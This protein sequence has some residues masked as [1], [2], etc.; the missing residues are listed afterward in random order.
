MPEN[1]TPTAPTPEVCH[2]INRSIRFGRPGQ[3]MA[4]YRY[5]DIEKPCFDPLRTP[6][7][8]NI[9]LFQPVD[10]IWHRGLW[11]ALKYVN[12]ENFWEEYVP[13]DTSGTKYGRHFYTAP[14]TIDADADGRVCARGEVAWVSRVS[15]EQLIT[16]TR[17]IGYADHGSWLTLDCS[18][19]LLAHQD[20]HL[21][22]HP[23]KG[24]GGYSGLILRAT[25]DWVET[26]ITLADGTE[27]PR[28]TGQQAPWAALTGLFDGAF[29]GEPG[30]LA[31]LDHP[32]NARHP[33][34]WYGA[35]GNVQYLN[36]AFV[37][38]EPL[39]VPRGERLTLNYRLLIFDGELDTKW[40]QQQWEA[41]GQMAAEP[42][43]A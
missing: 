8:H 39:D 35:T 23:F 33:S 38:H 30:G 13:T 9:S 28:P 32:G 1:L 5:G 42:V 4:V 19:S 6:A 2:Q 25:R 36:A 15:D 12:G 20:L 18:F 43:N 14:P 11:F 37:F 17:T 34:P 10:H 26:K 16:E 24:F 21:D 29:G 3:P 27:S 31:I 40:V 41:Y 22:R 7:G